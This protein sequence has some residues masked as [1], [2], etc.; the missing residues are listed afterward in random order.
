MVLLMLNAQI[1][2]YRSKVVYILVIIPTDPDWYET[3]LI[4]M[5]KQS[6]T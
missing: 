1:S 4:G 6:I 5:A 3:R 2:S